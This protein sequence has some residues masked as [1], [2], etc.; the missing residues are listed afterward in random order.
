MERLLKTLVQ[1]QR[2]DIFKDEQVKN[3]RKTLLQNGHLKHLVK[4]VKTPLEYYQAKVIEQALINK[5]IL[6]QDYE[7]IRKHNGGVWGKLNY[8]EKV[9]ISNLEGQRIRNKL[10]HFTKDDVRIFVPFFD[11]HFNHYYDKEMPIFDIEQYFNMYKSFKDQMID[12]GYYKGCPYNHF[13]SPCKSVAENESGYVLWDARHST[14]TVIFGH[15]SFSFKIESSNLFTYDFK[16]LGLAF[17]ENN[18][19]TAIEILLADQLVNR[20]LTKYLSRRKTLWT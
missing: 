2:H 6:E 16:N 4:T 15:D 1:K 12:V 3:E 13:F 17:I 19:N 10:Y 5:K 7:R 9:M 14:M 11:L 8:E 18:L 20:R